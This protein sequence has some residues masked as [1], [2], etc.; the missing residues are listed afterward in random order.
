MC[1]LI[2]SRRGGLGK[3]ELACALMKKAALLAA[4]PD[5]STSTG[6]PAASGGCAA[7]RHNHIGQP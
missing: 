7:G 3:T 1:G 5:T 2:L 6:A 4:I